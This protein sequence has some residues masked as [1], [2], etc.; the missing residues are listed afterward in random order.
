MA[1]L[2][3][4]SFLFLSLITPFTSAHGRIAYILADGKNYTGFDPALAVANITTPP[5]AAWSADNLG[6]IYV[7]PSLFNTTNITCHLNAEPGQ[8][9]V[10]IESG[11][12]VTLVWNTWPTSH[13]GPVLT[14]L[15]ACNGSCTTVDKTK[16]EFVKIDELG[17]LNSSDPRG[18][19]LGGTWASD[20]LIADDF[21]WTVQ[22]PA[23]LQPG[24]Y[25]LRHEIIALHVANITNEAQAYP[26]CV[27]L[28]VG[29][30][31]ASGEAEGI[32]GGEP[33]PDFYSMYGPGILVDV[34]HKLTGY[35][36]PGPKMWSRA[37]H[38]RQ[39]AQAMP[40]G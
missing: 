29:T 11:H 8:A 17:W 37:K 28:M 27:N 13:V 36:I 23:N 12:N 4:F 33:A 15:A 14:Y 9:Y 30:G 5:L 16:L 31:E 1:A 34:H 10:S 21:T 22:I 6:N 24:G 39:A 7:V 2:T 32:T 18:I 26:Q 38:L 35:S 19:Q 40:S 20:V 3:V 25:V